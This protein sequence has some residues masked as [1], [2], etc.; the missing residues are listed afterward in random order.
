VGAQKKT[1]RKSDA[2]W[3]AVY[4]QHKSKL[5]QVEQLERKNFAVRAV[6]PATI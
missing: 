4:Q 2:G 5:L 6:L 3:V 1:V